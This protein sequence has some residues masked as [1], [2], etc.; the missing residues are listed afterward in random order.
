VAGPRTGH[1][2]P[3]ATP[4]LLVVALLIVLTLAAP[5]R[6]TYPVLPAIDGSGALSGISSPVV[7]PGDGGTVGMVVGNPLGVPL[8]AVVLTVE[9]YEFNAYPGNATGPPPGGG[10][11]LGSGSSAGEGFNDSIGTLA[12]GGSQSVSVPFTTGAA[13]AQGTY[14]L[15]T[16]VTFDANGTAYRFDSRGWFSEGVWEN[17]TALP[18]G[19]S[20]LNLTRLGVSGVVPETGVLVRSNPY[21]PWLYGLVVVALVLAAAGGY[22]ATREGPG[23]SSGVRPPPPPK[24]APSAFGNSRTRD[25]D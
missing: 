11:V 20:T 5:V 4:V 18:G 1:G 23:S 21:T 7:A 10:L 12:V 16:A 24:S 13:A 3:A 14:A 19:A 17:A 9:L 8:A 6:A 25:G 2:G 22:Y 15:R